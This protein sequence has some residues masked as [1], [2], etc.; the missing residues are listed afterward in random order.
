MV[1]VD[2][3]VTHNCIGY[4]NNERDGNDKKILCLLWIVYVFVSYL[5]L[6]CMEFR[7]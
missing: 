5:L 6:S 7:R 3:Y 1:L 2:C 4:P